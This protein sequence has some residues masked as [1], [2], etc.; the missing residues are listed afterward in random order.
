LTKAHKG[1]V[2]RGDKL[3]AFRKKTGRER[4]SEIFFK[5]DEVQK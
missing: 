1:A 4:V 5:W 3:A 2:G